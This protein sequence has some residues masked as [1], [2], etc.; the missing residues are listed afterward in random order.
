MKH[1]VIGS[2]PRSGSTFI[3]RRIH[4]ML[5]NS[6]TGPESWYLPRVGDERRFWKAYSELGANTSSTAV[7]F[8]RSQ[9][10][11]GLYNKSLYT[12][13]ESF[14][15]D[16]SERT[17]GLFF[18]EKT[19]RNLFFLDD[20]VEHERLLPIQ[21]VRR[22]LD[23]LLSFVFTF[24][25]GFLFPGHIDFD[26]FGGCRQIIVNHDFGVKTLIYEDIVEND[27]ALRKF[28]I[29][30]GFEVGFN[31]NI[32][33]NMDQPGILGD[34]VFQGSV[35]YKPN[36]LKNKKISPYF[37]YHARKFMISA[38]VKKIYQMFYTD[39]QYDD[40][41]KKLSDMLSIAKSYELIFNP[42]V[43]LYFKLQMNILKQK[44]MTF[45]LR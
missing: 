27:I 4:E 29:D 20:L 37:Y 41:L 8:Y 26:L 5:L 3:Q 15:N 17:G 16:L 42:I 32:G 11:S 2:I 6:A 24:S 45:F 10:L 39:E 38:D 35:K 9:G 30:S 34:P 18:I 44:K 7:K 43:S 31:R 19:P 12:G 22:P 40:D 36:R 33:L 23:T 25:G 13:F 21:I 1:I 28:L 14:L